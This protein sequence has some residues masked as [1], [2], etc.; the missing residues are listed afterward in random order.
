MQT[1][2][3]KLVLNQPFIFSPHVAT[4]FEVLT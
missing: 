3:W 2:A 4:N 1:S